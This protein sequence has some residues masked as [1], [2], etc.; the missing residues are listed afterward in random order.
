[1][2][3]DSSKFVVNFADTSFSAVKEIACRRQLRT[4]GGNF[5][6]NKLKFTV[7]S[8]VANRQFYTLIVEVG[9]LSVGGRNLHT[10]FFRLAVNKFDLGVERN[11]LIRICGNF[12]LELILF[13][14]RVFVT[15]NISIGFVN[16]QSF[17]VFIKFTRSFR[18]L[19]KRSQAAFRFVDTLTVNVQV[20]FRV[21][22]FTLN[23]NLT[24]LINH[25]PRC[26]L[27]YQTTV[28]GFCVHDL[29]NLTL[30]DN[31]VTLF[32]KP[33]TVVESNHVLQTTRLSVYHVLTVTVTVDFTGHG[34][35]RAIEVENLIRVVK[36]EGYLAGI[37]GFSFERTAEN[38]V[39]HVSATQGFRR[40]FAKHPTHGVRYVTL[41][42][43]VRTYDTGYP[44]FK[45]NDRFIRKRFET[46]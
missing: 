2:F 14:F 35:F 38:N 8:F 19:G 11:N 12:F 39:L 44:F 26:F 5:L 22:D 28:F 42:A 24:V 27:E 41:T 30:P 25:K 6:V 13:P 1:M 17:A 37:V 33:D 31:R 18:L 43:T 7:F 23:L 9:K 16:L 45:S 46:A 3:S 36:Y 20:F 29:L 32:T 40:L 34:N 10:V 4:V 15:V 21:T